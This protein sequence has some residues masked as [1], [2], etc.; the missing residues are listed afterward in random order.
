[1]SLVNQINKADALKA[2]MRVLDETLELS[3]AV[4]EHRAMLWHHKPGK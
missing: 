2:M 3:L 4:L 1:M